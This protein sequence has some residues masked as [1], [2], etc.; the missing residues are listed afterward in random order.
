MNSRSPHLPRDLSLNPGP[1]LA[2]NPSSRSSSFFRSSFNLFNR[3]KSFNF[4]RPSTLILSLLAVLSPTRALSQPAHVQVQLLDN[5]YQLTING[6][7]FYIKGAG[8][9]WGSPEQLRAHGGN[10]FRTWSAQNG[11][12]SGK[13]VLDRAL[14]NH[15]CVAMGLDVDH[16]RR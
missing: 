15:L 16:E 14:T 3:F 10:S 4:G 7:P 8:I 1:N 11:R 9:E 2:L 6:K 5:R 12:D 13:T